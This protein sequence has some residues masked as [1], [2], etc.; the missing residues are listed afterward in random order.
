MSHYIKDLIT[1]YA[2]SH[3]KDKTKYTNTKEI[4]KELKTPASFDKE[5]GFYDT[6]AKNKPFDQDWWTYVISIIALNINGTMQVDIIT[7]IFNKFNMGEFIED[8]TLVIYLINSLNSH[9][10]DNQSNLHW[11]RKNI[12]NGFVITENFRENIS[13]YCTFYNELE[14]IYFEKKSKREPWQNQ[15]FIEKLYR[16]EDYVVERFINMHIGDN[17]KHIDKFIQLTEVYIKKNWQTRSYNYLSSPLKEF[18]IFMLKNKDYYNDAMVYLFLLEYR[19]H[20]E[21]TDLDIVELIVNKLNSNNKI[22]DVMN[23]NDI[24]KEY[25]IEVDAQ[26]KVGIFRTIYE[27]KINT[28]KKITMDDILLLFNRDLYN[29]QFYIIS[30][31]EYICEN[32]LSDNDYIKLVTIKE[33]TDKV[34]SHFGKKLLD[35]LSLSNKIFTIGLQTNN[36]RIIT[37]FINQK[38]DITQD[39]ILQTMPQNLEIYQK[40]NIY[41]TKETL[42]KYYRKYYHLIKLD[43][44]IKYSEYHNNPE[45]FKLDSKDI[46][47]N[48]FESLIADNNKQ[49]VLIK[50]LSENKHKITLDM[51][52]LLAHKDNKYILYEYYIK[53]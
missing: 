43:T 53:Q 9:G 14:C 25:N 4:L 42:Y 37:H 47:L 23:V 1:T 8:E 7:K 45:D 38:Y 31:I 44:L 33:F 34:L 21:A 6:Y 39:I 15:K 36:Q 46:E 40:N 29:N 11:I 12:Q 27:L 22:L 26:K 35:N 5:G 28:F 20:Y 41:M 24:L 2:D 52:L 30:F 48:Y 10:T 18:V 50:E 19:D 49:L 13:S 17:Q 3:K 16:T 51:I 32:K